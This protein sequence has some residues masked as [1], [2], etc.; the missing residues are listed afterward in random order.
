MLKH[1]IA[2]V[3]LPVLVGVSVNL[4]RGESTNAELA[5]R[6]GITIYDADPHHLW[7]R[8][9]RALYVRTAADGREVGADRL[10]PLL[11]ANT[12]HLLSGKSHEDAVAVLDE[13][14][15]HH[16][17][18]LILDPLRRAILQRDLWA[19]FDWAADRVG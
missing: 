15:N 6:S 17:E 3:T 2:I 10:D 5:P 14:L 12:R 4:G 9:H 8:L 11:W 16:G 19:V 7:N 18:Q 13:F 1:T